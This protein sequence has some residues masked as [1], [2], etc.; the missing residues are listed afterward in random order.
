MGLINPSELLIIIEAGGPYILFFL[1]FL[2]GPIVTYAASFLASQGI[3]NLTLVFTLSILGNIIPDAIL[4]F[5]GKYSRN[6]K[7][8]NIG[9][10]FGLSPSRIEGMERKLHKHTVKSIILSK[11]IPGL[12][13]PGIIIA[14][15][16]KIPPKKFFLISIIFNTSSAI[17]FT[18]LGFYSGITISA[19]LEYLKL[20][21]YILI[22][23]FINIII[24]YIIIKLI[25]KFFLTNRKEN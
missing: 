19:F 6:K 13:I 12:A 5:I 24:I 20:G 4:F 16:S 15:F 14:G 7:I 17:I 2:E 3:F 25:N 22:I 8:E 18:L 23:L 11:L 1:M 9:S 10:F 21:K